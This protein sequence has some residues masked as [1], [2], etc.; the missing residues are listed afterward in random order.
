M[1]RKRR[2]KKTVKYSLLVIVILSL[3]CLPYFLINISLMGDSTTLLDLGEK[4]SEPG[5][6]GSFLGNNI[7]SKI[8]VKNDIKDDIGK[9]KV[10][11]SYSFL[12]Y[13]KTKNR[14]VVRK[15]I[16]PPKIELV[17]ENNVQ[18]LIGQNY[19]ELGF[20][21]IDNVDGDLTDKVKVTDNIDINKIGKYEVTYTVSDSSK[22]KKVLK[23]I[24][25]VDKKNP[26]Q[27]SLEEFSLDGFYDNV[28]LKETPIN[29]D[30]YNKIVFVGDSNVKNMYLN[31]FIPGNQTWYLPCITAESYFTEKLYVPGHGQMLLLDAVKEFQPEYMVLSLG[32]FSTNW[33]STDTF[34]SKSNELIE[35]IKKLSPNTKLILSSIYPIRSGYNINDFYQTVINTYNFYILQMADKHKIKFLDVEVALKGSNGYA[36]DNYFLDDKFHFT[37]EG[38]KVFINYVK[39]HAWEE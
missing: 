11:Y 30:Y 27:M 29:N 24:V 35:S 13:K 37:D 12:F 16:S 20:K 17:G 39:T 4:F 28:K 18:L 34:M 15:D 22:N 6:T 23:R 33:I 26:T 32:T 2:I 3:I 9:Y 38:R 36:K 7:K 31:K 19:N 8:N 25:N 5:Y 1:R 21:A 10:S 14:I